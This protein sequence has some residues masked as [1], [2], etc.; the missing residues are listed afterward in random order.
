MRTLRK[1]KQ[2]MY[3]SLYRAAEEVYE[4]E[5]TSTRYI[6]DEDTGY[7]IPVE[8]G[9][10]KAVYSPPV[11]FSANITSNLNQM[12]VKAYGIDQSSIYSE[13]ICEKGQL[14][15]KVGSI[16]WRESPI[17]WDDETERIPKQS[18]ADYTVVGILTEY[19]HN[20]F[21]ML[22]RQT[23]EESASG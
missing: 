7:P 14:P 1:N 17:Q 23:P 15:L 8:I 5:G 18:S 6:T 4:E 22:Q 3:Y 2:A 21:Y 16:I 10:Q 19:Q 20:D 12:H 13:L 11:S 9:T